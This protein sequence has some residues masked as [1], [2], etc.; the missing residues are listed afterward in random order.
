MHRTRRRKKV[1]RFVVQQKL[2]DTGGDRK[3]VTGR[4]NKIGKTSETKEN[5]PL[6]KS[7]HFNLAGVWY[8]E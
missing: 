1:G 5:V 7:Q 2:T 8:P 4:E 6:E 3:S